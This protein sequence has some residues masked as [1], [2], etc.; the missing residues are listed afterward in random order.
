[1]IGASGPVSLRDTWFGARL[2][3]AALARL[4]PHVRTAT[5]RP[6][7]RSCGKATRPWRSASSPEGVSPSAC[8]SP[9]AARPRS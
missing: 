8:A 4:E 2:P 5:T 7:P 6:A 3:E 9:S 1:M